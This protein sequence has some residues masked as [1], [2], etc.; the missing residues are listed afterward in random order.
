MKILLNQNQTINFGQL[1]PTK[2]LLKATVRMH[3]FEESKN[4]NNAVG[5]YYSGHISFYKRAIIIA[6]KISKDNP[7]IAEIVSALKKITDPQIK[8]KE[9]DRLNIKYGENIDVVVN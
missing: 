2:P 4:L 7:E 1:V 5:V 6:D 3:N 8:M 9:I